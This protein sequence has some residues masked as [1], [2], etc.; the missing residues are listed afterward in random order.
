[1]VLR[2]AANW[3]A[4]VAEAIARPSNLRSILALGTV[5]CWVKMSGNAA[6]PGRSRPAPAEV[7]EVGLHGTSSC[8][9]KRIGVGLRCAGKTGTATAMREP[10][11]S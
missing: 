2:K 4:A 9:P 7:R 10:H 3:L 6:D 11:A 1:M 8:R 5:R